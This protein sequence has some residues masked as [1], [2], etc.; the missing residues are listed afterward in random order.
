MDQDEVNNEN[1][2]TFRIS[3]KRGQFILEQNNARES[4][5]NSAASLLTATS[6]L[7]NDNGEIITETRRWA[8][9]RPRSSSSPGIG[10]HKTRPWRTHA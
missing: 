1:W 10:S 9:L 4:S 2:G 5:T 3:L 7:S 6:S 8:S